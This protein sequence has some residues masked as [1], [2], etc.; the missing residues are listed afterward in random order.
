MLLSSRDLRP[1]DRVVQRPE[2]VGVTWWVH[3]FTKTDEGLWRGKLRRAHA[4]TVPKECVCAVVVVGV[5]S[6]LKCIRLDHDN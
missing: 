2:Y 6:V 3:V 4:H 5:V 1:A